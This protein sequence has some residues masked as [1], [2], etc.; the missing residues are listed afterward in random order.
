MK[1]A[2]FLSVLLLPLGLMLGG[3][4]DDQSSVDNGKMPQIIMG[5]SAD[6][7]PF[8][9]YEASK[10]VGYDIEIAQAVAAEIGLDLQVR[11]MDFSAL[12]PALQSGRVDFVMAS[13]T[14]TPER[15]AVVNFSE[16]YLTLPLAAVTLTHAAVHSE[17][18]LSGKKVGVQLGS[19]HEQ[20]ARDVASRDKTVKIHSLNKL[21]E[22]IQELISGRIDVVIMETKTA[23]SF[24]QI[25]PD[26][27]VSEIENNSVAFAMAFPK[28]S[29]WREKFNIALKKLHESG[30]LDEIRANWFS[31]YKN[32]S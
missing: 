18:G 2:N 24:Q 16:A 20:F 30:R 12:V 13:M 6:M 4:S 7:P 17:S 21:A 14:P 19:T 1:F 23:K 9:F 22:L 3:C 27:K 26:L 15:E 28:D 29:P 10:I 11:D 25:N 8:E 32:K 31:D 5:T